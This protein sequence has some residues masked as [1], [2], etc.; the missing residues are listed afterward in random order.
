MSNKK[1]SP[2]KSDVDL[3]RIQKK[4]LVE[5]LSL[6]D[7]EA[8]EFFSEIELFMTFINSEKWILVP[9]EK[10]QYFKGNKY[11]FVHP[12][13]PIKNINLNIKSCDYVLNQ[14]Q[15]EILRELLS[16]EKE[17]EEKIMALF[18]NIEFY[19]SENYCPDGNL[20]KSK[21]S[22][23]NKQLKNISKK[24]LEVGNIFS[25][26]DEHIVRDIDTSFNTDIEVLTGIEEFL[27]N[28]RIYSQD[29][30]PK[31]ISV[32]NAI[33]SLRQSTQEKINSIEKSG[34]TSKHN[35]LKIE[36]L[37]KAWQFS[38]IDH[39]ITYTVEGK[40][41]MYVDIVLNLNCLKEKIYTLDDYKNSLK[42]N[43]N[44]A[45]LG[46]TLKAIQRSET[47]K[48]QRNVTLEDLL[49]DENIEYSKKI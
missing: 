1:K 47:L 4:M 25:E 16:K 28:K 40:F 23:N 21:L 26:I 27:G 18:G 15:K 22:E 48:N 13:K 3:T 11:I 45:R 42:S 31:K 6:S 19:M 29:S 14:N 20:K 17:K 9:H 34:F 36:N 8:T 46:T 41:T 35:D 43:N 2:E 5:Y 10:G 38:E 12:D 24:L 49:E 32:L 7:D 44:L 37:F 30:F 33:V 39:N